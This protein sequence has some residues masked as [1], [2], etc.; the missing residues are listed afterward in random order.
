MLGCFVL[1]FGVV[2]VF[3]FAEFWGWCLFFKSKSIHLRKEK[4]IKRKLQIV[5]TCFVLDRSYF[6]TLTTNSESL[7]LLHNID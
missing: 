4:G 3:L 7:S 1:S 2:G 5:E 6:Y